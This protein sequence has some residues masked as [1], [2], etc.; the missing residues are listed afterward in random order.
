M[1]LLTWKYLMVSASILLILSHPEGT[2]YVLYRGD[3]PT[4]KFLVARAFHE[5]NRQHEAMT[6]FGLKAIRSLTTKQ[7][8]TLSPPS[9]PVL[10]ERRSSG[11]SRERGS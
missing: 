3:L 9:R 5:A 1:L 2:T 6:R 4:P 8:P 10:K 11:I 7:Q